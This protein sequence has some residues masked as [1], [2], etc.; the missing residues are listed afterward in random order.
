[1]NRP[2]VEVV[3]DIG[4]EAG[5]TVS[6][7]K[8]EVSTVSGEFDRVP[9]E[10]A[11][12]A[13]AE[14]A[15][16]FARF[17]GGI[18]RFDPK[19]GMAEVFNVADVGAAEAPELM[20]AIRG[21]VGS[22]GDVKAIGDRLIVYGS[23]GAVRRS[24]EVMDALGAGPDGWLLQVALVDISSELVTDLGIGLG[25]SGGA[26]AGLGAAL[27]DPVAGHIPLSGVGATAAIDAIGRAAESGTEAAVIT[28]GS[29]FLLE[30][31]EA[32]LQRGD[33]VPVPRRTVSD[34]G[35]VSVT[36]FDR[37]KTGFNLRASGR[38]VG[39]RLLLL[40]TPS[41]SGVAG[42]VEG[43]PIVRERSVAGSALLASGEW[44][45][46]SGLEEVEGSTSSSGIPGFPASKLFNRD[47][48]R[49]RKGTTIMLVRAV[50]V[51][52]SVVHQ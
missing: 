49:T 16:L 11:F 4:L 8:G 40:L 43:A 44:L 9:A 10:V 2:F 52:N 26:R 13:L 34:Q 39:D 46:M 33:V 12:R 50:R 30:G 41:I 42:F 22:E 5:V 23:S 45:I 29:L 19:A 21:V 17:E 7:P 1:M 24:R 37:I 35:T 38:R 27:G 48:D 20:E 51:N 18:V 6:L 36:G 31:R 32:E 14:Q 28:M 47:E 25:L 3:T 15:G